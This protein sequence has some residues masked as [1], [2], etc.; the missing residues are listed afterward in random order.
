[1]KDL[2]IMAHTKAREQNLVRFKGELWAEDPSLSQQKK[3]LLQMTL[4][5]GAAVQ[6]HLCAQPLRVLHDLRLD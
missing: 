1:M 4:C 5:R 6:S 2:F 3:D